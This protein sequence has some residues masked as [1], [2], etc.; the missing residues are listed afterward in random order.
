MADFW[1]QLATD[2]GLLVLGFFLSSV[3]GGLLTYL[4]QRLS[5][6]RQARLDLYSQRYREG[7]E[8]LERLLSHRPAV[9]RAEAGALG[10]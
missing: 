6:R 3:L 9:F 2:T 1:A 5:W 10:D 7:N 8:F 4:F